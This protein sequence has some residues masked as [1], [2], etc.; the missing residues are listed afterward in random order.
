MKESTKAKGLRIFAAMLTGKKITPF[1]ANE[2][3]KTTEGTRFIRHF[4]ERYPVKDEKVE[5]ERYHKYW[6]DEEF[7]KAWR[8][9]KSRVVFGGVEVS[10]GVAI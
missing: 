6:F 8:E 1:E 10:A 3:G 2:I 9:G 7:I 4:R 5:G